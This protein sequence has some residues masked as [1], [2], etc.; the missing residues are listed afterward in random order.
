MPP[1][2][3]LSLTWLPTKE[4]AA[5]TVPLTPLL[6]L[7][8]VSAPALVAAPF[9]QSGENTRKLPLASVVMPPEATLSL[10]WLPVSVEISAPVRLLYK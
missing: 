4:L 9:A 7:A 5:D 6:P 8:Q 2:A 10:A 3:T 1:E